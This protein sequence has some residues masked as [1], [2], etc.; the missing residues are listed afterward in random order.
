[1]S[2]DVISNKNKEVLFSMQTLFFIIFLS[3]AVKNQLIEITV[4]F[5]ITCNDVF[6]N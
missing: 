1:M 2:D 6:R 4:V 3:H 5:E